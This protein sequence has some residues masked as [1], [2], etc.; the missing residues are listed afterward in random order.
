[1]KTIDY[2]LN[3][4]YRL[5]IIPDPDEGGYVAR[6]PDLPGCITVGE[7]LESV[8]N[9][10]RDAKKAWLEAALTDGIDVAEPSSTDEYSG[11]F[12]LRLPKSLHRSLAEHSKREGVSMNQ[13]C[14]YLLSKNDEQE[15]IRYSH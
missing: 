15:K 2:Y 11:Q 13:Y 12:K 6:Y 9:N 10:A 3:L 7:T 1:M 5:E 4:P 8:V 14:V